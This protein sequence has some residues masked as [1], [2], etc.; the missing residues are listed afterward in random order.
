MPDEA[1]S[2]QAKQAD[3]LRRAFRGFAVGLLMFISLGTVAAMW[4]AHV[5][6]HDF[7]H[8][9]S[10]L[11]AIPEPTPWFVGFLLLILVLRTA[12]HM[13]AHKGIEA[14]PSSTE[15]PVIAPN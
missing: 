1:P 4:V 10:L 7:E 8:L 6:C 3:D 15:A 13:R 11:R 14:F 9:L 12:A 2:V 5:T